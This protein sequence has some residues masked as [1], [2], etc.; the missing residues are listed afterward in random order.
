MLAYIDPVAIRL[1]NLEIRWYA[2]TMITGAIVVYFICDYLFKKEGWHK[3]LASNLLFICFPAGVI[4]ARIWWVLS[5]LDYVSKHGGFLYAINIST[6][7]LAIQG[8]VIFGALAGIIYV[9]LKHPEVNVL[10]GIDIVIP[11]ILIAQAIGRWGNFA[12]KEVFG[13]CVSKESLS[14]LPGFIVDQMSGEKLGDPITQACGLGKAAQ[15]LFLYESL[16]NLLGAF[17]ISFVLRKYW[18]KYRYP[19]D[20]GALYLLWYGTVRIIME[21]MR[22]EAFIMMQWGIRTSILMSALFIIGGI[23]WLTFNRVYPIIKRKLKES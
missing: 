22:N 5:N 4:G 3:D 17:I 6:G 12:N 23:L 18:T 15:P 2:I 19:G 20:L 10:K 1:F 21:P 9:R 7:G 16:L 8:G 14:F 11:N 13:S